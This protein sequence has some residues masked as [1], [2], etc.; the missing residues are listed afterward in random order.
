MSR[1]GGNAVKQIALSVLR[2]LGLREVQRSLP[3]SRSKNV[4]C[5]GVAGA[6]EFVLIQCR[7]HQGE[8]DRYL[9]GLM[10]EALSKVD[11]VVIFLE[12]EAKF[13]KIPASFLI[14]IHE[15]RKRVGDASYTGA[16]D[17]QW[18]VDIHVHHA[19]LSP[20]GSGGRRYSLQ[21]FVI[22]PDR[23]QEARERLRASF[24]EP[25]ETLEQ[26]EVSPDVLKANLLSGWER[27]LD[28][29]QQV[30]AMNA[31]LLILQLHARGVLSRDQLLRARD[32]SLS[33]YN[34]ML[35]LE[36]ICSEAGAC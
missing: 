18:R 22:R 14:R 7:Q 30:R 10:V 2:D 28:A 21:R 26:P 29:L 17:E 15:E 4:Y 24:F 25:R 13:F 20:Q 35:R 6:S 33:P 19:E 32:E 36:R 5:L 16:Y 1:V 23:V 34:R 3:T 11:S 8:T 12:K 31:I 9:V 27:Q